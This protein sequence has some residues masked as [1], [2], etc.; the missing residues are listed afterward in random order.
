MKKVAY[1]LSKSASLMGFWGFGGTGTN[2]DGPRQQ[3][4]NIG[5][6]AC[7]GQKDHAGQ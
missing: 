7:K 1:I 3:P 5:H 2:K 6:H 4:D